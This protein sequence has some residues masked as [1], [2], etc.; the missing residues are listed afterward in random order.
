[1]DKQACKKTEEALAEIYR[2]AQLALQSI[3]NILPAVEDEVIKEELSRQHEAYEHFSAKASILARDAGIELKDPNPM[4]KVMMWGSIK[5]N[6]M[7]DNSRSHIAE[8]MVQ[9]T[10]MG[11]TALKATAGDVPADGNEKVLALLDEM[12]KAE[13]EFEKIWKG[14]L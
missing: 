14:Y 5:M 7:T 4:K 10:V 9:G 13:E 1:M 11:I 3:S 6:T 12:I 8:M 2:N